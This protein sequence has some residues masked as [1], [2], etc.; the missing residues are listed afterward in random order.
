MFIM[1]YDAV[2]SLNDA[3]FLRL[4]GITKCAFAKIVDI[5]TA[6]KLAQHFHGGRKPKLS[7]ENMA[8]MTFMYLRENR[9]YFHI[10]K[11][12]GVSE[13]SCWETV[14]WV[15]NTLIKSGDFTLPGKKQ[16][17]K[18]DVEFD[19]ILID[20]SETSIERPK[21]AKKTLFWQEKESHASIT[22]CD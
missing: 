12:Y 13:S 19:V 3:H 20:A 6:A 8:L 17:L 2:K 21:K 10:A 18:S 22:A 5:L 1:F 16:L 9:T 15:E 14:R 4:I 7:I 11:S